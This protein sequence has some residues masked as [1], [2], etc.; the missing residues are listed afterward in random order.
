MGY[1]N[2]TS[3]LS[4]SDVALLTGNGNNGNNS[5][6]GNGDGAWLI[7]LFLIFALSGWGNKGGFGGNGGGSMNGAIPYILNNTAYDNG[8]QRGF[9]QST[10]LNGIQ[11]LGNAINNGFSAQ[12]IS[13]CNQTTDILGAINNDRFDTVSAITNT[14]YALNNT[15][16]QNEMAR[17]QCCCDNKLAVADLKATI[18]SE[19]CS[20]REALSNGIRDIIS[21]NT[22]NTQA[23]LDKL[24][25]QEIEAYRRENENLRTQLNMAD[26]RA[27]QT[28]QTADIRA[29]N[30]LALN[31]LVNELRTC[32]IPSQ[33]V[34]GSQPIFSCP[35]NNNG[36]GNNGCNCGNF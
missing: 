6:F 34:Y 17:Q 15:M 3:G 26:L 31:Q 8:V 22:A 9:D 16:M 18:I 32:P 28:A 36:C 33:P 5:G 13:Q 7:I 23:I 12:A 11:N 14:G 19:N 21:S 27:S 29:N 35:N 10:L 2:G 30:A 20:D 25:A 4:A 1:E 24:C